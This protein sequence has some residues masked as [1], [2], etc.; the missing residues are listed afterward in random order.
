MKE[1]IQEFPPDSTEDIVIPLVE[2]EL[3]TGRRAV[4]TGAV[5]VDKHVE[6]RVQRIEAPLLH[7][8]VDIKRVMV[9]R[10]VAA[11]PAIR[12]VGDTVIVPVV[13]EELVITK[14]L[15]LKEEIH[16]VKRRTKERVGKDIEVNREHAEIHRLDAE[17]NAVRPASRE[18]ALKR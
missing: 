6:K 16:L 8:D 11:M 9:N 1:D 4:K 13:E 15:I 5:R 7:E 10:P 18:R 14:Q 12:R 17:G 3:A 2:E